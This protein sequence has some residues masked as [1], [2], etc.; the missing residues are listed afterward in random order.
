MITTV[1]PASLAVL[2]KLELVDA[3]D[4]ETFSKM[5]GRYDQKHSGRID[6]SNLSDIAKD[7]ATRASVVANARATHR[8][9]SMLF[10]QAG[11]LARAS[12]AIRDSRASAALGLSRS[13]KD[14]SSTDSRT[15]NRSRF[16][17]T[18]LSELSEVEEGPADE[19]RSE[20]GS[21]RERA[22]TAPAE[23]QVRVYSPAHTPAAASS[24]I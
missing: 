7:Y 8:Q 22:E 11:R 6:R 21:K 5:F 20:N 23:V 18:N 3:A 16:N 10:G 4:I 15:S 12:V 2:V 9:Q 24:K 19:G 1:R 14:S 13:R 17:K